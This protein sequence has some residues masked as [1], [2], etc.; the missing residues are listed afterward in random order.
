MAVT[1]E[2][3]LARDFERLLYENAERTWR[4]LRWLGVPVRKLPSDLWMLQEIVLE[5]RPQLVIETGTDSGGS[6]L[7][8]A[9]LFDLIGEGEVISVDVDHQK[10][11]DRT[12]EHPRVT[13]LD[14]S[15]TEPKVL[16]R[17]RDAA[18]GVRVMVNLDSDHRAAHVAEELLLLSPLVTPGCYLIVEDT[19]VDREGIEEGFGS[20]PGEALR[21]WLETEPPFEVDPDRERLYATL[22][23]GGYLRRQGDGDKVPTSL[24]LPPGTPAGKAEDV[25]VDA[26]E[27]PVSG[28]AVH[29]QLLSQRRAIERTDFELR[30][31]RHATETTRELAGLRGARIA[32]LEAKLERAGDGGAG[33]ADRDAQIVELERRLAE[34]NLRLERISSSLPL[35]IWGRLKRLPPFNLIAKRRAARYWRELEARRG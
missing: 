18:E 22:N 11:H 32:E 3:E 21:E 25:P 13:L 29:D 10:A 1:S 2:T 7:F 16:D 17:L 6:A 34:V 12:R 27:M 23:P 20:G 9:S 4:S 15:S 33:I 26:E 19:I 35:R 28:E 30:S 8:F 31:L 24:A 14:G 5:T